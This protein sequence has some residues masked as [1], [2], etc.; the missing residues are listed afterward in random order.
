M[1]IPAFDTK[2]TF[3][4]LT[5]RILRKMTIKVLCHDGSWQKN[6]AYVTPLKKNIFRLSGQ[7]CDAHFP[8]F[9]LQFCTTGAEINVKRVLATL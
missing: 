2:T 9:F 1:E 6:W 5:G 4:W 3:E 7:M 8:L